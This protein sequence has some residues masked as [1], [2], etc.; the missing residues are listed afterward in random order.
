MPPGSFAAQLIVTGVVVRPAL[1]LVTSRGE[2]RPGDHRRGD[3]GRAHENVE[4][5]VD[6][7]NGLRILLRTGLTG[8]YLHVSAGALETYRG[9]WLGVR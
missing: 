7:A 1:V 3:V 5:S 8:Y 4:A 6:E 9:A 2:G